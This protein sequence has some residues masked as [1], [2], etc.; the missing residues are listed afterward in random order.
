MMMM[1]TCFYWELTK[2]RSCYE[3]Y[4]MLWSSQQPMEGERF[5]YLH[6]RLTPLPDEQVE[7]QNVVLF[8]K[9]YILST[10]TGKSQYRWRKENY[11]RNRSRNKCGEIMSIYSHWI[12]KSSHVWYPIV[13]GGTIKRNQSCSTKPFECTCISFKLILLPIRTKTWTWECGIYKEGQSVLIAEKL[14]TQWGRM[15]AKNG[16]R[17]GTVV[18]ACKS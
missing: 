11:Q 18:Q 17:P 9:T 7:T 12:S 8:F 14:T 2:A 4:P 5:Y 16:K 15:G 6:C 10:R 13:S 1:I 3:H